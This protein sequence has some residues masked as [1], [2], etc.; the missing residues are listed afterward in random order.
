[1]SK[2][3]EVLSESESYE[4]EELEESDAISPTEMMKPKT[5]QSPGAASFFR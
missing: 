5:T 4:P 1:M 3:M 2:R